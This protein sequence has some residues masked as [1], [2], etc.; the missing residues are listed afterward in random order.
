MDLKALWKL[1]VVNFLENLPPM[2]ERWIMIY[3][4]R[5]QP[6]TVDHLRKHLRLVDEFQFGLTQPERLEE[7]AERFR[8]NASVGFLEFICAGDASTNAGIEYARSLMRFALWPPERVRLCFDVTDQTFPLLF[9]ESPHAVRDRGEAIAKIAPEDKT[10]IVRNGQSKLS[11]TRGASWNAYTGLE[12]ESYVLPSGELECV[13]DDM[14][15]TLLVDGWIVGTI[16]FGV[17]Y[18]RIRSGDLELAFKGNA[19]VRISGNRS[20]LVRD[21]EDA[22][23]SCPELATVHEV[24]IGISMGATVA[25]SIPEVGC[26]WHERQ[27]GVHFGL[28]AA[29]SGEREERKARHHVDIMLASGSMATVDGIQVLVW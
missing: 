4:P 9:S 10:F 26:I 19:L 28:G 20:D 14:E 15:G 22:V 17:K 13:P 8:N 18:G 23:L 25:A 1:S 11:F 2:I 24:G 7:S 29:V 21:F 3:D 5:C 27:V 12:L 16:P 6:L